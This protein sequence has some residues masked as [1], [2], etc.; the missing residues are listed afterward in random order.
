MNEISDARTNVYLVRLALFYKV[1]YE[2]LEAS[3]MK[4]VNYVKFLMREDLSRTSY[5]AFGMAL[6]KERART[7]RHP[8]LHHIYL[9]LSPSLVLHG[10]TIYVLH[11]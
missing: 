1:L 3:Y 5:V 7:P 11:G 10:H 9:R 6:Q 4:V 2:N 8:E